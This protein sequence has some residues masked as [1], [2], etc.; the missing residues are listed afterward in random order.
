MMNISYHIDESH[1]YY[2]IP[3]ELVI[4]YISLDAISGYSYTN[5][6]GSVFYLEE[7]VDGP[8]VLAALRQAGVDVSIITYDHTIID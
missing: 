7:D 3:T 6:D 8:L 1:G 4:Q 2:E 5:D